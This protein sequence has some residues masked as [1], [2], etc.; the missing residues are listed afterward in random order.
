MCFGLRRGACETPANQEGIKVPAWICVFTGVHTS[1]AA[2]NSQ[3]AR[4][5]EPLARVTHP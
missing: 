3:R 1:H 5:Y 4:S 2:A